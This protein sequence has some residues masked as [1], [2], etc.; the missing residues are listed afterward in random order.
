MSN[1]EKIRSINSPGW[2]GLEDNEPI[3]LRNLDL[4]KELDKQFVA[5]FS[6]EPGQSVLAHLRQITIEQPAWVPGAD[7]SFDMRERV[8]IQSCVKLSNESRE[9]LAMS[10]DLQATEA[11]AQE[12]PAEGLMAET[13]V[14]ETPEQIQDI[15]HK[16]EDVIEDDEDIEYERPDF[17]QKNFGIVMVQ[18]LKSWLRR[19]KSLRQSSHKVSTKPRINMICQ[20]WERM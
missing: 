3:V 4:Q 13:A 5:V 12:A 1:A 10:D 9:Q 11:E 14:E 7:P 6:T 17:S 16:A 20:P 8:K 15:P 18:I 2:D 19:T